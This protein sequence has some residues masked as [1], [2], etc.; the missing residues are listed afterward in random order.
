MFDEYRPSNILSAKTMILLEIQ[1]AP[2]V[3]YGTVFS[4]SYIVNYLSFNY[5]RA[6]RV[7][8]PVSPSAVKTTYSSYKD[9]SY[10]KSSPEP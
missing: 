2:F 4:V 6:P 10:H 3:V 8:E 5:F 9:D 7:E 1:M